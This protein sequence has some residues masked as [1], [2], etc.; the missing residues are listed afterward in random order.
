M[1]PGKNVV[2]C[3]SFLAGWKQLQQNVV[4][5]PVQVT[6]ADEVCARLNAAGDPSPYM[7][8]ELYYANAGTEDKG[9]LQTIKNDMATRFPGHQIPSFEDI[10]PGS[11]VSY[12]YLEARI[13]FTVPYFDNREPMVFADGGG[14][15]VPVK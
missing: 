13:P 5:G 9:I 15:S 1:E 4:N 8:P 14:A 3:A 6:G 12:S 10:V 7:P 2:W 11:F